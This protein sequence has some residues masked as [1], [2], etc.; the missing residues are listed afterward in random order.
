VNQAIFELGLGVE[1]TSLY[2]LL[3]HLSDGG[4]PLTRANAA[5][6][7]NAG[8]QE[9]DAA[10]D[11]LLRRRVLGQGTDGRWHLRPSADWR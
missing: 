1:A 2:L 9:L 4:T 6:I 7:W 3:V 11:E 8:D 10:A 5:T